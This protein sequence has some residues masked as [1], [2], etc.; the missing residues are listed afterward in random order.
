MKNI[1]IKISK[2]ILCIGLIVF[3]GCE[4]DDSLDDYTLIQKPVVSIVGDSNFSLSEEFGY[5]ETITL[6]VS[7]A[8]AAPIMLAIRP[9]N[10][11]LTRGDFYIA[12]D[13]T[14]F[15]DFIDPS[16]FT[17][18]LLED[19]NNGGPEAYIII[20]PPYTTSY[21]FEI[22]AISDLLP[23]PLFETG[24]LEIV[25]T[26][27]RNGLVTGDAINI[28]IEIE[29]YVFCTWVLDTVDTYGDSWNGASIRLTADGVVTDYAN[30]GSTGSETQTFNIP[31]TS[32]ADY[33]FE[34]VSGDWDGEIE[35]TLTSP[36]GTVWADAYYPAVGLITSGVSSCD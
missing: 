27:N 7:F 24:T 32:G 36:D 5:R 26:N 29:D 1:Y 35:Y 10:D 21:S 2:I 23:E 14:D 16:Y 15:E 9:K 17:G 22:A 20:I 18:M 19:T 30:D 8:I 34:F 11:A 25:S 6:D 12:A 13:I 3:S 31:V 4:S 33:T 28:G